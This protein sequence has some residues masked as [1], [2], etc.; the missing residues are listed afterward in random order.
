[1]DQKSARHL[2]YEMVSFRHTNISESAEIDLERIGL[3]REKARQIAIAQGQPY[4]KAL[5]DVGIDQ[6]SLE[7]SI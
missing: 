2:M 1:M 3:P 4:F 6:G 5:V 7:Q